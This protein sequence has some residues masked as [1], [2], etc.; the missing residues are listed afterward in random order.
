MKTLRPLMPCIIALASACNCEGGRLTNLKPLL[1]AEPDSLDFG[2]VGLGDERSLATKLEN[3]GSIVLRISR[4]GFESPTDDF[5]LE[6][7]APS[8]IGE[9]RSLDYHV[10]FKPT[11]LGAKSAEIVIDTND[12]KGLHKIALRGSGEL[13]AAVV[14][15]DGGP[16]GTSSSSMSFGSISPGRSVDRK[17]AIKATGMKPVTILSAAIEATSD[18]EFSLDPI[19]LPRS[20]AP[21]ESIELA[22]HYEPIDAVPSSGAILITTDADA[23]RTIRLAICGQGLG[24]GLCAMRLDL[25]RATIGTSA[26]GSLHITSCGTDPADVSAIAVANEPAHASARGLH[27]TAPP[28]LPRRLAPMES[29]EV[30]VSFDVDAA[31]PLRGWIAAT[32]NATG[33][34]ESFF[35]V[36]VSGEVPCTLSVQPTSLSF[37]VGPG[38]GRAQKSVLVSN[39]GEA[40][41]TLTRAT[42]ASGASAFRLSPPPATPITLSSQSATQLTVEYAPADAA[43]PATGSL[44]VAA[45]TSS[46]TVALYGNS[47]D[48]R[49]HLDIAP[50]VLNFGVVPVGRS[51]ALSVMIS[52]AALSMGCSI[53]SATLSSSTSAALAISSD[54]G[55]IRSGT[56]TISVTFAPTAAGRVSG[57]LELRTNDRSQQSVAIPL[58]GVSGSSNIC[59]EPRDLVFGGGTSALDFVITACGSDSVT[60]SE[61]PWT[62]PDAVFAIDPQG[63][64]PF[65]LAIGEMRT[66]SV[67]YQADNQP[68]TGVVTVHSSDLANPAI[69]V[70]ATANGLCTGC[71]RFM[72]FWQI[73]ATLQ[74]GPDGGLG[75]LPDLGLGGLPDFG[76]GDLDGGFGDPPDVGALDGLLPPPPAPSSLPAPLPAGGGDIVR[77]ALQG[78]PSLTPWWGPRTGQSCS[79]CH[80]ISPDGRYVAVVGM[81][82]FHIVDTPSATAVPIPNAPSGVVFVSW[83]P[84][85]NTTPPYQFAYDDGADIHIASVATGELRLL[86]GASDPSAAEMMP[87]W[88]KDGKIAFVRSA[89]GSSGFGFNGPTDILVVDE[90]GGAATAV[91]GASGNGQANYYPRFSPNGLW[92]A[93]TQSARA[94]TTILASDAQLRLVRADLS[95]SVSNLPQINGTN[96]AS[97]LSTWSVDGR[98]MGFSSNRSG[99]AGSWDIYMA[100]IDPATGA[101][102]APTNIQAANTPGFE[103]SPEWSP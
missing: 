28:P 95:G 24:V 61:L 82:E 20:L 1:V 56:R 14:S 25:G 71:G 96:G 17:I 34:P 36:D 84:N 41:C 75:G 42:I 102:G 27:I 68:H 76:V 87:S 101:D 18:P 70:R 60:V 59:V 46:K 39:G 100:P 12:G 4:F 80:S 93:F 66:V 55:D 2:P 91:P 21:E 48:G 37:Y 99:G 98:S 79:G 49:C 53:G 26:A 50:T 54:D 32:S 52:Q 31:Q 92:I 11:S 67:L 90:N 23:T 8:M 78:R 38:G 73:A 64:V 72:Y 16:C 45:G 94:E 81:A 43:T 35:E 7:T 62:T 77:L 51:R 19:D 86:A 30:P 83:N 57:A 89:Q 69:D 9:G 10:V 33:R 74:N 13:A 15:H 22:A 88:G 63:A 40:P 103:F 6:D 5:V 65:T 44:V 85:V 58:Y 47:M 97:S 29:L 3:K